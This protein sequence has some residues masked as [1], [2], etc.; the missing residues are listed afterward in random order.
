MKINKDVVDKIKQI[1]QKTIEVSFDIDGEQYIV[2][3]ATF[4]SLEMK[5]ELIAELV[6]ITEE[7]VERYGEETI[8]LFT[9]IKILTDIEWTGDVDE[10]LALF[11]A[12]TEINAIKKILEV[13]PEQVLQE[14]V[15]FANEVSEL[16]KKLLEEERAT[17]KK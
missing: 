3:V 14:F 4:L 15:T 17:S 1:T 9:I 8:G 10:D 11:F 13:V 16:N 7:Q 12:L 2:N 6:K 5:E